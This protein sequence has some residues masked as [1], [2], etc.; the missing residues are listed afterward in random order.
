M[1]AQYCIFHQSLLPANW[2]KPVLVPCLSAVCKEQVP[3]FTQAEPSLS[4]SSTELWD[5]KPMTLSSQA[6]KGREELSL[7]DLGKSKTFKDINAAM[8]LY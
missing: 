3:F 6:A 7:V 5:R 1:Y 8:S 2:A 4:N